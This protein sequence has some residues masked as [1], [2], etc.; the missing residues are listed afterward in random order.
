MRTITAIGHGGGLFIFN[1]EDGTW[2]FQD[3]V[4]T[5]HPRYSAS[6]EDLAEAKKASEGTL[7]ADVS[8][9]DE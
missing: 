1:T 2:D 6:E 5:T 9:S 4:D 7:I 8:L 3:D